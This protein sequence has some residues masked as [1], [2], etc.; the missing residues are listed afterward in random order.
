MARRKS[1]GNVACLFAAK[2]IQP[3][4]FRQKLVAPAK[5]ILV[6]ISYLGL[7]L[8]YFRDVH[9]LPVVV[10][11]DGRSYSISFVGFRFL[12]RRRDSRTAV[13]VAS[14]NASK[15]NLLLLGYICRANVAT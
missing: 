2:T 13:F 1:L 6:V 8:L 12:N 15:T 14:S 4:E 11:K 7:P 5:L 9:V 10:G 3:F